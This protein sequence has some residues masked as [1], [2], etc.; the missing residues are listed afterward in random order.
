[1]TSAAMFLLLRR[2]ARA[3]RAAEFLLVYSHARRKDLFLL[4]DDAVLQHRHAV[5]D[6]VMARH[7]RAMVRVVPRDTPTGCRGGP[8]REEAERL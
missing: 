8:P 5:L 6:R 3:L 4:R 1:M 7:D 2:F